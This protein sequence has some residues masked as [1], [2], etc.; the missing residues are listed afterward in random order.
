MCSHSPDV[1]AWRSY[2]AKFHNCI[3]VAHCKRTLGSEALKVAI[4]NAVFIFLTNKLIQPYK[5]F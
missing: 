2:F 1:A 4:D 5:S 3:A